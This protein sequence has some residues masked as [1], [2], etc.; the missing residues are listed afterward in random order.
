[1]DAIMS[2]ARKYHLQVIEDACEALGG[3]Y[4]HQQVGTLGDIG[5]FA[6]YPNKQMTTGE[7]GMIV[8][9]EKK[10]AMLCRSMRN[11]GRGVERDWLSHAR[12]GY[13]YRLSDIHCALGLAQL[14]RIEEL[15]R[16]RARAAG[17]YD[18]ALGGHPSVK[19][20]PSIPNCTRSWFVYPV[21]LHSRALRG[22]SLRDEVLSQLRT[23]GIGCQA[24]FPAIHLQTYFQ[25]GDLQ[26]KRSLPRTEAASKTCLILPMFSSATEEQIR[27]V[28]KTLLEVLETESLSP[29]DAVAQENDGRA[30]R[31]AKA[32]A[33]AP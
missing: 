26:Q 12:L 11:Q 17:L 21:Q 23:R 29:I 32:R 15:L 20:P 22:V 5:V 16:G 6:F 13:N 3:K 30:Y 10:V 18:Q 7:G 19:L 2:L 27:Y 14:E 28:S 24:Y 31:P 25:Q 1:M 33:L 9:N 8:T 4:K